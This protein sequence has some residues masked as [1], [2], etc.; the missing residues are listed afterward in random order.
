V[1][2]LP[3]KEDFARALLLRGVVFMHLDP[4]LEGV[5][6]P[7]WLRKQPQLVLSIGLDLPIPIPDLRVDEAGVFG[8]LSFG[9]SPFACDVPW[10]AVF[11]LVGDDGMGMVW[12]DSMPTEIAAEVG[13]EGSAE[14]PPRKAPRPAAPRAGRSHLRAIE[15]GG[16]QSPSTDDGGE[17]GADPETAEGEAKRPHL[18]LLK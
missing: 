5:A 18:R 3:P 16:G 1:S 4:R 14:A 15:G 17:A 10:E 8:T 7:P 12:P 13:G 11:A 6:V 9:G 2:E